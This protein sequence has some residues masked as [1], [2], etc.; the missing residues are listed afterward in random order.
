MPSWVDAWEAA[1]SWEDCASA[2]LEDEL[3]VQPWMSRRS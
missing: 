2:I 1:D 3:S